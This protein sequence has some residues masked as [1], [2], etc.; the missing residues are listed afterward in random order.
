MHAEIGSLKLLEELHIHDLPKLVA[1]LDLQGLQSLRRL[2]IQYCGDLG[3]SEIG[4]KCC[5][6]LESVML[7]E[8]YFIPSRGSN[9]Y[10][11]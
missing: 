6:L 11:V 2:V 5:T 9:V 3:A 7:G 1:S 8:C 4:L 10:T